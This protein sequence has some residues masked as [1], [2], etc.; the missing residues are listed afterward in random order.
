M[1]APHRLTLVSLVVLTLAACGG[2]SSSTPVPGPTPVNPPAS[3]AESSETA[4]QTGTSSVI[5]APN[6]L[7]CGSDGL[8]TISFKVVDFDTGV[9][10][11]MQCQVS[12]GAN[13]NV[14]VTI[15]SEG[16]SAAIAGN[17]PNRHTSYLL[18]PSGHQQLRV[19]AGGTNFDRENGPFFEIDS[20]PGSDQVNLYVV[21]YRMADGTEYQIK[22]AGTIPPN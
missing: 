19:W 11:D 10:T 4:C 16:G 12:I 22:C 17:A 18:D 20:P 1:S 9:P 5:D 6:G 3:Q 15:P 7:Q 21:P 14:T 2:N 13:G 8:E